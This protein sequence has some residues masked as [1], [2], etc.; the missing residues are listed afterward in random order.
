MNGPVILEEKT[1]T[2]V[3]EPGWRLSADAAGN[4]MVYGGVKS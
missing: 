1:S 4:R 2:V 3:V